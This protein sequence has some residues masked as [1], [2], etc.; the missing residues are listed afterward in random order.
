M[1]T[2]FYIFR[3]ASLPVFFRRCPCHIS[4]SSG[5]LIFLP[6]PPDRHL[7]LFSAAGPVFLAATLFFPYVCSIKQNR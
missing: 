2:I 7:P 6:A 5:S 4:L 3:T 1:F